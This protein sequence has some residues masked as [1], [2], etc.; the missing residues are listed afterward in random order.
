MLK[1][2]R[3][4][5][6]FQEPCVLLLGGFDGIHRGHKTLIE[7]AK[8]R[9][10][11]VGLTSICG[12]KAGGDVFTFEEREFVFGREG[13]DFVY[14]MPF[15]EQLKSTPYER[16]AEELFR[17]VA[18]REVICGEDFR[19]GQ[20]A[21]GTPQLLKGVARRPVTVM[22]LMKSGGEK[23][24]VSG[25]KK[26]LSEG[27][28]SKARTLLC[29]GY[30]IGGIVSRGR[31]VGKLIGFPTLNL[32]FPEGKFCPKEGVY[33]GYAE[34]PKGRYPAIINLGG[35]PTFGQYEYGVEAHLLG[36]TGDLYGAQV[37][38]YLQ[39]YFRSAKRFESEAAL[40]EQLKQDKERLLNV[41]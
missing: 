19:F 26:L 34:T 6:R 29:G 23:I 28:V 1:V 35:C 17:D 16:F 12:N 40:R 38:V 39:D 11:P 22:R 13:L 14:E 33:G 27:N 7:E 5:E 15:T 10:L 9:R 37:R 4:G 25:V 31:G 3:Q 20:G 32:P 36:F 8:T 18:A 24:A 30:F 2:L 41:L 21:K